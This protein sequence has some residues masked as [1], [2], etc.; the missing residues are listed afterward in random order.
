MVKSKDEMNPSLPLKVFSIS[1]VSSG[2][3]DSSSVVVKMDF[4]ESAFSRA[5]QTLAILSQ[6]SLTSQRALRT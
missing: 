5:L 1:A 3:P 6:F 2:A 4:L